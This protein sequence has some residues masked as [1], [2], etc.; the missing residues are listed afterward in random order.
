MRTFLKNIFYFFLY[1]LRNVAD[2]FFDFREV[3]VLCYHSINHDAWALTIPPEV[4][5]Q[6]L[7]YLDLHGYHFA[8]LDE[9]V[10]YVKGEG[11]LPRKSVALTFDDGYEDVLTEA[12]PILEKYKAPATIFVITNP[13]AARAYL[14]PNARVLD[15]SECKKLTASGLVSL[16]HHSTTHAMLDSIGDAALVQELVNEKHYPY[17][18]YPGGH[19]SEKSLRAVQ[20]AGFKAA[21]TIKQGLVHSSDNLYAMKRNVIEQRMSFRE[22]ALRTTKAVAWYRFLTRLRN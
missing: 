8:T 14:K 18:A 16:G 11:K 20:T 13:E 17:F 10:A 3:S 5:E 19:Y 12:L 4:F 15:V 22:F 7:R 6:Q 1:T 21:F 9:I 2:V